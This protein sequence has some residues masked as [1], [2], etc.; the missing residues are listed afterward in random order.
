METPKAIGILNSLADQTPD[1]RRMVEE[2]MQR[3]QKNSGNDQAVNNCGKN[4]INLR[5]QIRN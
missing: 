2:A 3:V 1:G 4:L 5:K